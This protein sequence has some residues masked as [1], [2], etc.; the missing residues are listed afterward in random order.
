MVIKVGSSSLIM[1]LCFF[2]L[3]R[4][5]PPRS[6]RTDTLFPYTTL[7]RSRQYLAFAE[8]IANRYGAVVVDAEHIAGPGIAGDL[9]I[10]SHEGERIGELHLLARA[11]MQ[12]LHAWNVMT[13][14]D[15]QEGDPVAM[16]R[17]HVGLNLEHEA[18]EPVFLGA[19]LAC[20]GDRNG[21]GVGKSGVVGVGLDG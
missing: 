16:L 1:L 15:A 12:R 3:M 17:V 18:A 2:F 13:G 21:L 19:H 8:G 4:R 11:H 9:A 7:F 10:R 20:A 5:R 14:A 6:T